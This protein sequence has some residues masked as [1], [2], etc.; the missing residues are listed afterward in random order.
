MF[1]L[2]MQ[3]VKKKGLQVWFIQEIQG[4]IVC[5]SCGGF[6]KDNEGDSD[7]AVW[8]IRKLSQVSRAALDVVF[9]YLEILRIFS[10]IVYDLKWEFS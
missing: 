6:S 4:K 1:H 3:T 7:D 9:I 5:K 10:R 8:Y 2:E